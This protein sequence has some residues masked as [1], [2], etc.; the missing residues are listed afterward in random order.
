MSR[1][2]KEK[3]NSAMK[4][5]KSNETLYFHGM[6]HLELSGHFHLFKPSYRISKRT[7]VLIFGFKYSTKQNRFFCCMWPRLTKQLCATVRD[8]IYVAN[9]VP[10]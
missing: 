10:E 4:L 8:S 5:L 3:E 2:K 9:L 7:A 6:K 1:K